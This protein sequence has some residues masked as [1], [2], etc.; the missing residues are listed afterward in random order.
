[1]KGLAATGAVVTVAAG[2]AVLAHAQGG[3][4]RASAAP[5][6]LAVS[7]V[8]IERAA[9]AGAA[10]TVNVTNHSSKPL[11]ITVAARPWVQSSTGAVAPNRRHTLG[12]VAVSDSSFTLAPGA[13]KPVTVTLRT[14]SATYGSVEVIGLPTDLAT[15]KGVVAGYRIL[16]SLRYDPA[17]PVHSLK[18]GAVKVTGTASSRVFALAITNAGNTADPVSG[19]VVVKGPLGTRNGDVRQTR[20]LPGKTI[21]VPIASARG[22][23]AGSYTATITLAQAG[24]KTKITKKVRIKK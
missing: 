9:A 1:M 8:L 10:N 23:P 6:G 2:G 21:A 14:A 20:V 7:P 19:E 4:A 24:Q 16:G 3:G 11:A 15:R 17:A 22:L 18:P 12:T 5:G 13:T